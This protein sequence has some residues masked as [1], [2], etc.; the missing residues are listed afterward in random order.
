MWAI[1]HGSMWHGVR[2]QKKAASPECPQALA[3]YVHT[4]PV[5]SPA[6]EHGREWHVICTWLRVSPNVIHNI[7]GG[8]PRLYVI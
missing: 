3:G 8:S 7:H 6:Q 5:P 4:S 2:K 1:V